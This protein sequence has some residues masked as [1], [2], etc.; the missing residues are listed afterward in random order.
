MK[1]RR[2]SK[3]SLQREEGQEQIRLE[4]R[5]SKPKTLASEWEKTKK[6]L[7]PFG[8][9]AGGGVFARRFVFGQRRSVITAALS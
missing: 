9:L 3:A 1:K 6:A 5:K 8:A 7:F 4:M 2:R